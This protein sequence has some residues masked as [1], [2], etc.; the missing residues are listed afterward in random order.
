MMSTSLPAAVAASIARVEHS[1][2]LPAGPGVEPQR[3]TL[4]E[5]MEHFKAP[6]VSVAVINDYEL[7]W[8]RGY[9]VREVG[10]PEPVTPDTLFQAGSISKPVAAVAVLR[11]VEQGRLDL[12]E[13]VNRYLT[14]WKVPANGEWQ[15]RVTLRHLLCHGGGLTVHGF[16]GYPRGEPVPTLVQV[17]NGEPPANTPAIRV[18]TLPGTQF[19]YSGG[20]T[21]VVQQVLIDVLGTPFPDL[22]RALVLERLG[23]R[24]SGYEQPLPEA[25]WEVAASGHWGNQGRNTPVD[26][27][28][29]VY[30]E[31]AAAGLWTTPSDL[32]RFALAVQRAKVGRSPCVLATQLVEQMLTPQV[33]EQI[34]LG[35]FLEGRGAAARF[36][37]GGGDHGFI[38][39]LTAYVEQGTG[40]VVMT[41]SYGGGD[42]IPE[43]MRAI[44]QE[45]GWPEFGPKQKAPTMV[46]PRRLSAY[47]GEYELKP[48]VRLAV[49]AADEGLSVRLSGQEAIAFSP[50]SETA[51]FSPV[52]DAELS[53]A[54]DD[55]GDISGLT[56]RQNGKDLPAKKVG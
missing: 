42:L 13:D 56:V 2:L 15:P 53:F 18:D 8:A 39:Q 7:E 25:R 20:G 52:V 40:A 27:Q 1:L 36:G 19:R 31:M 48:G 14:S 10:Q 55:K 30:P 9:G 26:G 34:G 41:N 33:E 32:A 21:S 35:F 37:H 45:Y 29:H 43:I 38:C 50:E 24:A 17:L 47:A 49:T 51:Y 3:A 28:W 12:D 4:A 11:L 6:G 22:A 23:M 5:R 16:P 54:R 46:N 44:A